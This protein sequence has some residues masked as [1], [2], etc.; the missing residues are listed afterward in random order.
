MISLILTS[1][2]YADTILLVID[3]A[4]SCGHVGAGL[5]AEI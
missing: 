1:Y 2:V 5:A 3:A 4:H